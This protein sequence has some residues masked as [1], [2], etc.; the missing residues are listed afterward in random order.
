MDFFSILILFL[1]LT[2]CIIFTGC[3]YNAIWIPT[4]KKDYKRIAQL[5]SLRPEMIFY[6][7]GSG[8]SNMLFYFSKKYGVNCVGVEVS[9]FWYFYS[10]IKSLFY[11]KVKIMYGNFYKYD[12]SKAD[13]VYV[14]L[15]PKALDKL[16]EKF[17]KELKEN[18]KIILSCWPSQNINP[19]KINKENKEIPD[20]L[21][22][23]AA[24]LK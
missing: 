19:T 7:L 24:L 3:L 10:K 16:K 23:K 8:S 12:L 6:D 2:V 18:S 14:F 17:I 9:P 22:N 20:D 5:V 13:I 15:T 11:K 21:Y 1:I 4:R